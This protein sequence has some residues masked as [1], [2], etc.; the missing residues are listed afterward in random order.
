MFTFDLMDEKVYLSHRIIAL[1]LLIRTKAKL[2]ELV[3]FV[4][5]LHK[6]NSFTW[7]AI[8]VEKT[9]RLLISWLPQSEIPAP[10]LSSLKRQV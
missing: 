5:D 3:H 8:K 1:K 2:L 6:F 10:W 4:T 9:P 7:R